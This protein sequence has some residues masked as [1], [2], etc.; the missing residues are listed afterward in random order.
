MT[1]L[2]FSE[3]HDFSTSVASTLPKGYLTQINI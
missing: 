1:R 2:I 3:L